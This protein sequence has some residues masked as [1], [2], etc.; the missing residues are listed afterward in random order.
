MAYFKPSTSRQKTINMPLFKRSSKNQSSSAD[1]TPAQ[2]PRVSQ[3]DQ[4]PVQATDKMTRDQALSA[5][6]KWSANTVITNKTAV[7]QMYEDRPYVDKDRNFQDFL[8]VVKGREI[9][10]IRELE[11]NSNP[12]FQF[13]SGQGSLVTIPLKSLTERLRWILQ[14]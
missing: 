5:N 12:I 8:R 7:L 6:L 9:K 11:V 10:K 1:S 14:L 13:F 4:R 3:E 2:T